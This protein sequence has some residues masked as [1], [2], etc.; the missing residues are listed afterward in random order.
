M[1]IS[2]R[3]IKAHKSIIK[4]IDFI[5]DKRVNVGSRKHVT[6]FEAK[7]Y[8]QIKLRFELF[9]IQK[10]KAYLENIIETLKLWEEYRRDILK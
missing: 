2:N 9:W 10:N 8:Q 1:E 6:T 3:K 5:I 7:H 4:I